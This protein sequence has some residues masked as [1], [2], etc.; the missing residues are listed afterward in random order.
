[1]ASKTERAA[2]VSGVSLTDHLAR[3]V[4]EDAPKT[5][6]AYTEFQLTTQQFDNFIAICEAEQQPSK[7]ILEAAKR[8]DNEGF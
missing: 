2:L 8:L 4:R 3:L 1:M 5:L 6:K 7:V